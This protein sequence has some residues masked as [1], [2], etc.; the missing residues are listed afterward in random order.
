MIP[1]PKQYSTNSCLDTNRRQFRFK[2]KHTQVLF[3]LSIRNA[4][5]LFELQRTEPIDHNVKTEAISKRKRRHWCHYIGFDSHFQKKHH[6]P[7]T[8]CSV[9][10][11]IWRCRFKAEVRNCQILNQAVESRLLTSLSNRYNQWLP[12]SKLMQLSVSFSFFFQNQ[13][14]FHCSKSTRASKLTNNLRTLEMDHVI[15]H[16]QSMTVPEMQ[17]WKNSGVTKDAKNKLYRCI[18]GTSSRSSHKCYKP[19]HLRHGIWTLEERVVIKG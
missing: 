15:L 6:P 7:K 16:Q 9:R 5:S 11:C 18:A 10:R 4:R 8:N 3:S 12:D 13:P 17:T 19:I 1:P 2:R 14:P